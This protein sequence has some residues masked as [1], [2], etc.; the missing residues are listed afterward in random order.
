MS[1]PPIKPEVP[2]SGTV[3]ATT[4]KLPEFEA[5]SDPPGLAAKKAAMSAGV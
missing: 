5:E 1:A 3:L 2:G 4:K